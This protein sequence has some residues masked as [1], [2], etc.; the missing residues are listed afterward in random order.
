MAPTIH[1]ILIVGAGPAGLAIA[2]R[3]CE[4]APSAV[5]TDAEHARYQ[6]I[7]KHAARTNIRPL[8][9][10]GRGPQEVVDG[11]RR[12]LRYLR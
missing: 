12:D 10:N 5:F 1:D 3:L 2:A 4:P 8:K 11:P 7:K 6:W 9:Q